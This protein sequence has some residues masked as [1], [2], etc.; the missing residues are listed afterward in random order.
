MIADRGPV[1]AGSLPSRDEQKD[2][3]AYLL[4]EFL[5]IEDV[6]ERLERTRELLGK[7]AAWFDPMEALAQIPESWSVDIVSEFLLRT[8]RTIRSERNEVI[9][10][11]GLS[12]AQNLQMQAEF[13]DICEK[14][15][16]RLEDLTTAN[17]EAGT[18]RVNERPS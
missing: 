3:F 6:V 1:D 11:K 17:L 12:A 8:F 7:F 18:S 15:G 13:I 2:L 14:F 4:E 5:R 16:S 10:V 9:I